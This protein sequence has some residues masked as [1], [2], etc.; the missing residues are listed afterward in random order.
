MKSTAI[1]LFLCGTSVRTVYEQ[2]AAHEVSSALEAD[3][4]L[5][6]ELPY[7]KTLS[8]NKFHS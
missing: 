4:C 8:K 1:V 3:N 7:H 5:W 6:V 2:A